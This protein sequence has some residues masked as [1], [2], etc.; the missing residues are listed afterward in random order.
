MCVWFIYRPTV[1]PPCPLAFRQALETVQYDDAAD[2]EQWGDVV[3]VSTTL[4]LATEEGEDEG[5][6]P[7]PPHRAAP[8][9]A[10]QKQSTKAEKPAHRQQ[11]GKGDAKKKLGRPGGKRSSR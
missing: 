5:E 9:P 2:V 6:P 10:V 4:G 7:P 1:D 3:T 8:L 11:R